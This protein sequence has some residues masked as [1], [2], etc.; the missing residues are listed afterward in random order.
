V[1][2]A[3]GGYGTAQLGPAVV[4]TGVVGSGVTATATAEAALAVGGGSLGGTSDATLRGT[5][6]AL[7]ALV[8]GLPGPPLP[9]A[10]FAAGVWIDPATAVAL[11][12]AGFG[13]PLTASVTIPPSTL[14]VGSTFA[15]QGV[16][17]SPNDGFAPSNPAWFTIR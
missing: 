13:P 3:I 6:G 5:A 12:A 1:L 4:I 9:F 17:W 14:L 15:W 7:G 2:S 8:L 11:A 10:G 16:T